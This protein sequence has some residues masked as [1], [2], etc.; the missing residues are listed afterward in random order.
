MKANIY[1][2]CASINGEKLYKIGY[3]RRKIET[4]LNEF[5]TANASELHIVDFF[6]SQWATK[7][8]ASLHRIFKQKKVR[9]EWFMLSEKDIKAF[10][11]YCQTIHD[12]FEYIKEH[13]TY[14]I[15][16]IKL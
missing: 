15:D 5:K 12:N 7:I 4:R 6:K 14:F 3:T 8:E 9:G 11:G 10:K 2:I 1:L 16:T 13:N